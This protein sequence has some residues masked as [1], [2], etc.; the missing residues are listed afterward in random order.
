[1]I[2]DLFPQHIM[3]FA[4][5]LA[6]ATVEFIL[7]EG[8]V[9]LG[10]KKKAGHKPSTLFLSRPIQQFSYHGKSSGEVFPFSQWLGKHV[11]AQCTYFLDNLPGHHQ[12]K[13][14]TKKRFYSSIGTHKHYIIP[15]EPDLIFETFLVMVVKKTSV[16]WAIFCIFLR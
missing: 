11:I 2:W 3:N 6:T 16:L 4:W 10:S 5:K 1:M 15:A 12:D 9:P 8:M 13:K 14:K 7:V